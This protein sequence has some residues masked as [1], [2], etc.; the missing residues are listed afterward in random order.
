[1]VGSI[2]WLYW[3][4]FLIVITLI[5]WVIAFD[6]RRRNLECL[7]VIPERFQPAPSLADHARFLES[8]RD[9]GAVPRS[10]IEIRQAH[11]VARL[12]NSGSKSLNIDQIVVFDRRRTHKY[13]VFQK[14]DLR[15]DGGDS[16]TV[17]VKIPPFEGIRYMKPPEGA[18]VIEV[19]TA[20]QTF[21]SEPFQFSDLV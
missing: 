3:V 2:A 12:K 18:G 4:A 20:T 1:M 10:E 11:L 13:A 9:G 17:E 15:L 7:D 16:K 5:G 14:P 6:I 8:R 21:C 19:I